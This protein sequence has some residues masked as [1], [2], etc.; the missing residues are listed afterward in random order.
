MENLQKL[1]RLVGRLKETSSSNRKKIILRANED[2]KELLSLVYDPYQKF[3]I[4]SDQLKK[5]SHL[6]NKKIHTPDIFDLL[7][8][9]STRTLTGHDA[10]SQVNWF[11]SQNPSYK[12]TIYNIIDR[13]LKCRIAAK[14]IN[15]VWKGAIKEFNVAL[16]QKYEKY[17]HKIDLANEEWF[18]SRKFDG[19]RIVA[20][21]GYEDVTYYSRKG[22]Q[23]LTLSKLDNQIL[24][25]FSPFSVLDGEVCVVDKDGNENFAASLS[26]VSRKDYT[27]PR[28]IFKIFDMLTLEE[29][30]SGK[31]NRRLTQRLTGLASSLMQESVDQQPFFPSLHFVNQRKIIDSKELQKALIAAVSKQ[32]EGLILRKNVGYRGKRS[33]DMLKLKKFY[34]GEYKVEDVVFDSLRFVID[35]REITQMMLSSIQISHKGYPVSVG[36]GFSRDQRVYYYHNPEELVGKTVT[37][38]YFEETTNKNGTISLRFPTVKAIH[39]EKR[40]L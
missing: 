22:H 4:T 17:E 13:D 21:T 39:G 36:S 38:T 20:I 18:A 40:E 32:W 35:G 15:G 16:A 9:L 37:V 7:Q 8:I 31:S 12:E 11:I 6:I 27:V 29:F 23:I 33:P 30:Q 3:H 14:T 10:I 25:A 28:P 5:H 1:E 26:H 34:D 19:I 2:C 24:E